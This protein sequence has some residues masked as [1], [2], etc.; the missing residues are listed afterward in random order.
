MK[1]ICINGAPGSGKDTCGE[2]VKGL[3]DDVR[4]VKFA[5]P[6]DRIAKNLLGMSDANFEYYRNEGKECLL[7]PWGCHVT[8]RQLLIGISEDL[9]KPNFGD[10]WFADQCALHIINTSKQ[11]D[12][13]VVTDSGF[14]YEFD[15]FNF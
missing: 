13:V 2:L 15:Y 3:H 7:T 9:I 8:M 12:L 11:H 14:Q 4:V 6:L 5:H 10:T 1:I